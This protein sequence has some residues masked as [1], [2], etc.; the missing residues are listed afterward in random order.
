[1]G[2]FAGILTLVGVC[3]AILMVVPVVLF[4]ASPVLSGLFVL[5]LLGA[6]ACACIAD[7]MYRKSF[8]N[9][10]RKF[11]KDRPKDR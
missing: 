5:V 11:E 3:G 8:P 6:F 2:R 4:N 7:F 1:L 9:L 10:F